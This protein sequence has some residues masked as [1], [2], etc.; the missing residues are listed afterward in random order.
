MLRAK[1]ASFTQTQSGH[2]SFTSRKAG[3]E[4]NLQDRKINR[5]LPR[6]LVHFI[7]HLCLSWL[8][9]CHILMQ[10]GWELTSFYLLFFLQACRVSS[11]T[12]T[13]L[14]TLLRII[15]P[16]TQLA[17]QHFFHDAVI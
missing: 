16:L 17:A 15:P 1:D 4:E 3:F 10:H 8:G 2:V 13:L 11:H 14:A 6:L 5:H 9:D 12:H 7:S